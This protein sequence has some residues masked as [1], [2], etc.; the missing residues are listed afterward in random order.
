MISIIQNICLIGC[1]EGLFHASMT[2]KIFGF[3]IMLEYIV[4]DTPMFFVYIV[5]EHR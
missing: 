3:K 5:K 1:E 2:N 4:N